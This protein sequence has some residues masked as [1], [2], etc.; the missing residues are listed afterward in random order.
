MDSA[1][2]TP[3]AP[4][5]DDADLA[6]RLL[7]V[8]PEDPCALR[9]MHPDP[10]GGVV[11]RVVLPGAV[12]VDVVDAHDPRRRWPLTRVHPQGVFIL[13]LNEAPF[14]YTLVVD[15]GNAAHPWEDAYR[16]GP[17]L[18][19]ET[20]AQLARGECLRL[21]Q[22]LGAHAQTRDGVA[23]V[24]FAVWAP[25]ARRVSVVGDFNRW[26]GRVHPLRPRP[27]AGVWELFV[28]QARPGHLYKFELLD[29]QGTLLPLKADPLARQS[30]ALPGTASRILPPLEPLWH[31][32][33][34]MARRAASNP[35]ALPL[36]VYEVHLGS[37]RRVPE[38]SNRMLTYQELA[39]RLIAHAL[40]LGF[41]HIELLPLH[42]HPADASWG[43]QPV[44]L[45]APNHRHGDPLALRTLIDRC[46]QAGLGVIIDWVPG[47]FPS[48]VHG[49]ARFDGTPLYEHPDLRH[50]QH[51][52]WPSLIYHH[53]RPQVANLL[54]AN[55]LYWLEEFHVDG[56][57]VGGVA[58]ML[59]LEH[60]RESATWLPP[61]QRHQENPDAV[62]FLRRLNQLVRT[63]GQGAITFAEEST[64]RPRVS[65]PA[66]EDGLGFHFKWNMGWVHDTLHYMSRD[67]IH[68][69]LSHNNL[70]FGLLYAFQERFVLA[71]GH[72]DCAP[73]RGSP[74]G[75]MPGDTWQKFANMRLY[76]A[77][78]YA[79]PGKKLLFMGTEFGQCRE[80]NHAASLDWHL[81][82]SHQRSFHLGIMDLVRQLNHLHRSLSA[83]HQR[84]TDSGGFQWID[85]NDVDQSIVSFIRR[86]D[87]PKDMLLAV[88]NF[89]PVPRHNYRV[90]APA[91]GRYIEL[92]NT[93]ASRFAGSGLDNG[94][95]ADT[96]DIPCHGQT[97]CLELTLPP[98]GAILLALRITPDPETTSLPQPADHPFPVPPAAVTA[99]TGPSPASE[100]S[101][102]PAEG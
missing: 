87:D 67:P 57:R 52:G 30:E 83:L 81:L 100:G 36:S 72:D 99:P 53:G 49:L 50:D 84:D 54:L 8:G 71:L 80:W 62:D 101:E 42:E 1:P 44:G 23:G 35:F 64:A 33:A 38:E 40:D 60:P 65:W 82:E 89:T 41:T 7:A 59:Y 91:A 73:G 39:E 96:H 45:F 24:R 28:P 56:L 46:H 97:Q 12:T 93:D 68:R 70:T 11:V 86:G 88:F 92:L 102:S 31:D 16:F 25:Y 18:D 43:Y 78:L 34:W 32:A 13:H 61:T 69:R 27:E 79:H 9:G 58:T 20:L 94:G 17:G 10:A 76:L 5:L 48:D 90:G 6:A 63:H 55:A 26:D 22:H 14:P 37:W 29:R 21:W 51:P 85:C 95:H 98:L 75:R 3:A 47:H 19:A 74:W 77:F 2:A 15:D 4:V 66:Q